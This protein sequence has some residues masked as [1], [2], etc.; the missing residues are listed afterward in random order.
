[1]E[2]DF[3]IRKIE[4]AQRILPLGFYRHY[5]GDLYELLSH[6]L[7]ANTMKSMVSYRSCNTG[8]TWFHTLANFT[9]S[10]RFT[11]IEV[12]KESGILLKAKKW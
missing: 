12:S 3:I 11:H 8:H 5:K 6:G 10:G 9:R 4:L 2:N 1:M 7:N